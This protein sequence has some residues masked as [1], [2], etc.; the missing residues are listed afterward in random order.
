M[1]HHENFSQRHSL[2]NVNINEM[3]IDVECWCLDPV[4]LTMLN[5]PSIRRCITKE[6]A[7]PTSQILDPLMVLI[8]DPSLTLFTYASFVRWINITTTNLNEIIPTSPILN[9][10]FGSTLNL[11]VGNTGLVY[12]YYAY[13]IL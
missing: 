8:L 7:H 9:A 10:S 6:Q 3:N 1:Y 5:P 13:F 12:F 11:I 4:I 2:R